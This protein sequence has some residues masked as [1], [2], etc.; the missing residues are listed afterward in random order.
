VSSLETIYTVHHAALLRLASAQ[1][2][3]QDAE[4]VLHDAVVFMLEAGLEPDLP[5]VERAIVHVGAVRR[6]RAWD[7]AKAVG[8][9]PAYET[10]KEAMERV[11]VSNAVRLAAE[12]CMVPEAFVWRR[13]VMRDKLEE[14]AGDFDVDPS[15]LDRWAQCV[16]RHLAETLCEVSVA[17]Q[18]RRRPQKGGSH[19][20][21]E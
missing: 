2:N 21:T 6:V 11:V 7:R 13:F 4:D 5:M 16:K 19:D 15:T 9:F 1:S 18:R 3:R 12:S 17:Q 8:T 20:G 14:L 10:G